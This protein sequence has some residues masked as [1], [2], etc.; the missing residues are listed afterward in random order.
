MPDLRATSVNLAKS[1]CLGLSRATQVVR[2]RL[3]ISLSSIS[4]Y[5]IERSR[6]LNP[7]VFADLCVARGV[8]LV[9]HIAR[10]ICG[11]S[12]PFASVLLSVSLGTKYSC[13]RVVG[14]LLSARVYCRLF[15][16]SR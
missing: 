2:G 5:G 8:D 9:S 4:G 1:G 3:T 14:C 6:D 15:Q 7:S 16:Q 13:R 12:V 11:V 10:G